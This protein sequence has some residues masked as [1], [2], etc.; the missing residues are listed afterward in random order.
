M[1]ETKLSA[2]DLEACH[3]RVWR[4]ITFPHTGNDVRNLLP[5]MWLRPQLKGRPGGR[6]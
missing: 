3:F 4:F 5:S 2:C 1:N 6:P